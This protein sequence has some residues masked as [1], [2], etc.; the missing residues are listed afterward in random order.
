MIV[1]VRRRVDIFGGGH[2]LDRESDARLGVRT[3][4][5]SSGQKIDAYFFLLFPPPISSLFLH[6]QY[7]RLPRHLLLFVPPRE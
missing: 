7:N 6:P 3:G 5:P 1:E 2:E 4:T